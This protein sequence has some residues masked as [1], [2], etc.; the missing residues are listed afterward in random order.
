MGGLA[1]KVMD[2]VVQNSTPQVWTG[3]VGAAVRHPL[4]TLERGAAGA[5]MALCLVGEPCGAV[6]AGLSLLVGGAAAGKEILDH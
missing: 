4:E 2:M 6:E 5:L 1:G 3:A